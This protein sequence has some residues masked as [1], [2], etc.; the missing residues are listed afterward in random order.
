MKSYHEVSWKQFL[1]KFCLFVLHSLND[2]LIIT[3][4]VEERSTGPGA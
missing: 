4:E 3:G 1:Q 2:V